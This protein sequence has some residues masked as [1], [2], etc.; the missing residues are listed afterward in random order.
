M[1]FSEIR[2]RT[3][4]LERR[5]EALRGHLDLESVQAR[6]EE[7]NKKAA[8][9]TFWDDPQSA[10]K[11]L[12]ER[13]DLEGSVDRWKK[14]AGQTAEAR[15]FLAL[16]EEEGDLEAGASVVTQLEAVEEDLSRM[17]I[18]R[19]LS[20]AD[21]R[22]NAFV[23]VSPGAGGT[24]SQDWAEMLL[25]MYLRYCESRRFKIEVVDYQPGDEAGIKG[26]TFFVQGELAY[27]Y[28]KAEAGVHRLVR[29]SPFDAAG[30]RHT[31]FAAVFVTPEIDDTVVVDIRDE[32]LQVDTFRSGGKGGQHVNKTESAVRITHLPTG[33]V[34]G[35]QSERS[36]HKNK[37]T[38]M[39]MLRSK[40]YEREVA[41]REKRFEEQYSSQKK[42]IAW[43]NQIRSYVL[44]PY[45]LVKDHRT[46]VET[47]NVDAV[48]DG[49]L[50]QFVFPALMQFA[51]EKRKRGAA[52]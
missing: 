45:R 2:D 10:Q 1:E 9:P 17:E 36:Q 28:L 52:S 26:V 6:I 16:A 47:G 4:K 5:I 14:L 13:A 35:C 31:S 33:I 23:S 8:E 21:D 18:D 43:G 3:Q 29:I 27:G 30:R 41:I 46:D 24:E 7:L 20:G 44:A 49:S 15:D 50:D 12:K 32:D 25:R 39:K 34:V 19:L 40:L 42:D 51:A 22:S 48:L 38:A 37:S 11:V